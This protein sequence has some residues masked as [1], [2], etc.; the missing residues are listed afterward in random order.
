MWG[1]WRWSCDTNIVLSRAE[2]SGNKI[3]GGTDW[4]PTKII[5]QNT[6]KASD[7]FAANNTRMSILKKPSENQTLTVIRWLATRCIY[8]EV[9]SRRRSTIVKD[10]VQQTQNRFSDTISH[11][12]SVAVRR[13]PSATSLKIQSVIHP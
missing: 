6:N 1:E 10:F 7:V 3:Y 11:C 9:L 5:N 12:H 2:W 4:W 13:K 8:L